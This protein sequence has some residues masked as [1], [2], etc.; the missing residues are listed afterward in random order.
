MDSNNS[1]QQT[2]P[3]MPPQQPEQPK[4][5]SSFDENTVS[6]NTGVEE[7]THGSNTRLMA[8]AGV[9]VVA[10]II[11]IAF[12]VS[13]GAVNT[14]QTGSTGTNVDGGAGS[15]AMQDRPVPT[16]DPSTSALTFGT[17]EGG[18]SATVGQEVVVQIKANSQGSDVNGYDLLIPYDQNAFEI[19]EATSAREEFQI[20]QFDRGDYFS[21]TGIK[22]L[23]V[24]DPTPF[25]DDAII[26][27][28]IRPKMKGNL[29]LEVAPE[30]G[31]ET[32][33]FVDNEVRIIKPQFQPIKLE[34]N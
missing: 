8:V 34:I 31:R 27:L 11:F 13:R 32:S 12:A 19:I 24:T 30:I 22:L 6:M 17:A 10:V 18:T 16:V 14:A 1:T 3:P 25:A 15:S 4:T 28:R 33:K 2:M 29:Y 20:Y 23:T 5:Q 7:T 9:M 26:N 21:I